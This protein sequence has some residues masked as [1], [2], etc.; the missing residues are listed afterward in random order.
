MRRRKFLGL[1]SGAMAWPIGASAQSGIPAVAYL[2]VGSPDTMATRTAGFRKGLQ[3]TGFIEGRT[4]TV[5]Y[6]WFN[7]QYDGLTSVLQDLNKRKLAAIAIPGSTPISLAAKK[8]VADIPIV[9]G[10]AE[11]PV[12]LGLVSS[13]ARPTGNATGT[14]FFAIEIDTKRLG[15]MHEL[16]PAAKKVAVLLN[17][18]N[19]RY[20][21][22]TR[23]AISAA[24]PSLGIE[25]SFFEASTSEEIETAFPAM[26]RMNA[27]A[28]F[29]A[30][31]AFFSSRGSQL[32]QLALAY[33][34]PAC[35][36]NRELARAGLLMTYGAS[37]E[38]IGRQ[39]GFYVGRIL[40]GEK[41]ADLPVVQSEKLDLTINGK[42]AAALGLSVP[43]M[44]LARADE[45]ID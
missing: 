34:L 2:S 18:A 15:L 22:A 20:S 8:L 31:E 4:V 32:S 21:E 38:E 44:M 6:H 39:I 14:N 27:G 10:V 24:A 13:L 17:P 35:S 7:G 5:E 37:F 42:T 45:V 9:F 33:R 41:P 28:L 40:K 1:L 16:V 3:E 23:R 12:S 36:S 29:V 30:T 43:P 26:A 19:P 25:V 11:N